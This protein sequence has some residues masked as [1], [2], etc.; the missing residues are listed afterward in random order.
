MK[1]LIVM[2]GIL[3]FVMSG[4]V[5]A[6]SSSCCTNGNA[7]IYIKGTS[8]QYNNCG[9]QS[10]CLVVNGRQI[11]FDKTDLQT[12]LKELIQKCKEE[13]IEN[14]KWLN[15]WGTDKEPSTQATTKAPAAEKPTEATTKAPVTEKPTQATTKAPVTEKPT[16]ATTKAPVT[17]RPTQATTKAEK[18]TETTTAAV[19]VNQSMAQQ[20]LT[21]V[22]NARA[23][24][25]L[26]ALKLNNSL[27][28]VAQKKAEDMKNK[29]YFSHTSPTYGS[30]FDMMRNAGITYK[31]AGENIA[32]GQKTAN[33][34]F[35]AWM[36]STG[37]RQNIL[38]KSYKEM[39]LGVTSGKVYWSQ[40]F[41]G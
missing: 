26:S 20:V 9:G 21:L 2:T 6:G 13:A 10:G 24:N 14:S 36:N 12:K 35:N 23:Q 38:N 31:T 40:M 33:E 37:H 1:K 25:G 7:N 29:N 22:N 11:T 8:Q 4:S 16:Q 39:G 3:A 15:G 34:V 30:P 28:A 19:N 18:T 32:Y 41:I 17:E 27:S 5:F